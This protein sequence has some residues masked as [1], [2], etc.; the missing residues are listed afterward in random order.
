MAAK[1]RANPKREGGTKRSD[2]AI[3]S[4][5]SADPQAEAIDDEL[6]LAKAAGVLSAR[7]PVFEP[8][9]AGDPEGTAPD[10]PPG[11]SPQGSASGYPPGGSPQGS[12]SGYPPAQGSADSS[13]A[14]AVLYS[15][16]AASASR[17][18][19]SQGTHTAPSL[20]SQ[21]LFVGPQP[22]GRRATD[23]KVAVV[24]ATG[25]VGREMLALLEERDFPVGE[26]SLFASEKS[27]GKPIQF[28]GTT[29]LVD[30]LEDGCFEDVDLV[31]M[32]VESDI[33]KEWAPKAVE[34]GAT[35]IDNS[36]AFRL[37]P[38]VPLVVSEVNPEALERH[39]GIISNPNCTTMI[40]MPV[41][42]PL[43]RRFGASRLIITTL[44]SVSGT[45]AEAVSELER[46]A[47][48]LML[49]PSL[50][51]KAGAKHVQPK[52][53]VY[54]KPI[55]FNVIPQC[56][57]FADA[58]NTKEELKLRNESRKILGHPDLQVVA[59]CVRVPVFVGHSISVVAEFDKPAHV[60]EVLDILADAPGVELVPGTDYPTPLEVA[61]LDGS[62]VGRVRPDPSNDGGVAFW[63]V[64]DNIRKGAALNCIEIAEILLEQGWL[65]PKSKRR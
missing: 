5:D 64:G 53:E 37:E 38:A 51:R 29:L 39:E 55:A 60:E 59:T 13:R 19:L 17:T 46:Q 56:D 16:G 57:A 62:W 50:L 4:G 27:K 58:V 52:H 45:G 30:V 7:E 61:G 12:A 22:G 9:E 49:R 24:G 3:T 6:A 33:A 40:L 44:Q 20:T 2:K 48:E 65:K 43:H 11:R 15:E 47:G 10:N 1:K 25:L 63:V 14:A 32:E 36:S 23:L 18:D 35:V 8:R 41:L 34:A 54:P 42:A 31:L 26:L 21:R 28:R